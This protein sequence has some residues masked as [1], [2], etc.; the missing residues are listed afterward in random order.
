MSVS[1]VFKVFDSFYSFYLSHFFRKSET[2]HTFPTFLIKRFTLFNGM[3]A[4]LQ[5]NNLLA[6][7]P[8]QSGSAHPP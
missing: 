3:E 1:H 8:Y 7:Y 4:L 2:I 5:S 6:P